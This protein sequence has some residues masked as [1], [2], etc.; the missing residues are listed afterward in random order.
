MKKIMYVLT[1]LL[2]AAGLSSCNVEIKNAKINNLVGTW[3]L[4]SETTVMTDGT[5]TTTTATKGEYIVITENTFTTVNGSRQ[6]EYPFKFNDPHLLLD[7]INIYDL[8]RLTRNEMVLESK[9]TLG[10]LITDHT[11][12]YKRR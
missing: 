9:L 8:K 5:Q 4:V 2:I 11:Y 3:D 6:T 7:D 10:I 1:A 12:T